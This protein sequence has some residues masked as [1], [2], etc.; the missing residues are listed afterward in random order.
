MNNK[1]RDLK[2]RKSAAFTLIELLVVIAIIAILAAL[3]LPALT[4][5]RQRALAISCLNNQRQL[6][7]AAIMYSTDNGDFLPFNN[8]DNG[9]AP[10]PGW[11]Y[12]GAILN[13]QLNRNDPNRC[14]Q[15]GVLWNSTKTTA[16]YLCPVDINNPYYS[17][18]PN[19]L[20]S[21]IWNGALCG[22]SPTHSYVSSK[23]TAVWSSSCILFW[24][25]YA[26]AL[27]DQT[28]GFNDGAAYPWFPGYVQGL[29][30]LHNK[31]G[32]NVARLDGSLIFMKEETFS[33][34]VRTPAGQGPGPGGKT[35]TWW[36]TFSSD[37]H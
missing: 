13:P 5:A 22:F 27:S 3:L 36:S 19:Q 29:G 10:G 18:R 34:D 33:A 35:L 7:L 4:K 15:T 31:T 12:T 20:S 30:K 8:W 32:A 21:Y 6:I 14:W 17:Q 1:P 37:G 9:T 23:I 26:P 2:I 25:P 28:A 24:E 16:V 11:L